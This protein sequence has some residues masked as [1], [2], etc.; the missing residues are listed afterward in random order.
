MKKKFILSVL[1]I[2]ILTTVG[3]SNT[4]SVKSNNT[5][6]SS[7]ISVKNSNTSNTFT[8]FVLIDKTTYPSPFILN[9][10]SLIFSNWE[11]NN[12][13]SFIND[14]LPKDM[15]S[16]SNVNDFVNYYANTLTLVNNFIYFGDGSS[17]NNL[18]SINLTDK[19]Y[20]KINNR[21]VHS[22]T[23]S[24]NHLFYLDIPDDTNHQSKLYSY[25]TQSGVEKLICK[26][27]IGKY[28]ING[29]FIIY[30]NLSDGGK[31][32]KITTDGQNDEKLTNFSVESFAPYS[33]ELLVINSD[34]NNTLYS[35]DTSTYE[36]KRLSLINAKDLKICNN[37]L[38]FINANDSNWLYKL[39][40]NI[41]SSEVKSEPL[42]HSSV[43]DYY[44]SEN[45]LFYQTGI[46]VNNPY[47]ITIN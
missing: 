7:T 21:N 1:M 30:Q 40:V 27:S 4:N 45:T 15:I 9:G 22:I 37:Q 13:I 24:D 26:N 29:N 31:L 25:D 41:E 2:S 6:S 10:N 44:F 34:D 39:T 3:C 47:I 38:F 35:V 16:K 42:V 5:P 12:R 36:A 46:N 28:L 14:N 32:Y 17:S 33:S 43:N 23:S 20:K 18:A 19:S 8:P 11:E